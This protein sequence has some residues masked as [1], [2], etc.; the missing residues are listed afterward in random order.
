MTK[1]TKHQYVAD[2]AA[3]EAETAKVKAFLDHLNT[4]VEN[5]AQITE[6]MSNVWN[7]AHD[8]EWELEQERFDI[9]LRWSQRDWTWADHSH[10][11]LVMQNID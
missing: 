3:N 11:D 7:A 5:G 6:E 1:Y 9:E 8:R 4:K 2:I 10:Y